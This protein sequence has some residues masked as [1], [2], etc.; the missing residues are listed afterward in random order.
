[1]GGAWNGAAAVAVAEAL[2]PAVVLMDMNMLKMNGIEA[3]TLIK[4]HSP[5]TIVIGLSVNAGGGN[6]EA[7]K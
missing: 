6:E 3:T 4:A 2:Q 7:M 1:V 5:N